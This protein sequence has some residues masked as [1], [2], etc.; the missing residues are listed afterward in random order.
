MK[1]RV[2]D[3]EFKLM[4]IELYNSGKSS[5]EIGREY[6]IG[7]DLA[8]RWSREYKSNKEICF[9]GN[10]NPQLSESE[11]EILALKKE[12]EEVKLEREI[13][14]KAVGIFSKKDGKFS[15]L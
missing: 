9:S 2:Y 7:H 3:K 1:R 8:A 4:I 10:G 13:L 14:K 6:G 11:K 15:N 12:L 5:A